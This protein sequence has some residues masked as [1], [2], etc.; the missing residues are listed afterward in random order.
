MLSS[1]IRPA[2]PMQDNETRGGRAPATYEIVTVRDFLN[3]PEDRIGACLEDFGKF[4]RVAPHWA[5]LLKHAS[6]A[7]NGPGVVDFVVGE[8][9]TWV[10]DDDHNM[11][12]G[13]LTPDGEAIEVLTLTPDDA[14]AIS[15]NLERIAE[16]EDAPAVPPGGAP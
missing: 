2:A 7:I 15:R 3:V 14:D 4:L 12:L 13:V 11:S 9:F 1:M 5:A 10:D 16:D 8:R 6:D